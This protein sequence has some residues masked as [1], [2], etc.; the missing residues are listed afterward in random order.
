[1]VQF[2]LLQCWDVLVKVISPEILRLL[3]NP[4]W[5]HLG[6]LLFTGDKFDPSEV[7]YKLFRKRLRNQQTKVV[8]PPAV[9]DEKLDSEDEE[10][11]DLEELQQN[12]TDDSKEWWEDKT[13]LRACNSK[14]G[15]AVSY[16]NPYSVS[17]CRSF[18][19]AADEEIKLLIKSKKK[20]NYQNQAEQVS[21]LNGK[22]IIAR[23]RMTFLELLMRV[24][25]KELLELPNMRASI[26]INSPTPLAT[27]Q[28]RALTTSQRWSIYFDVI[29]TAR[30]LATEATKEVEKKLVAA[31][32]NLEAI[33]RVGDG[34]ILQKT[35]VVGMTTT[36]AAK[37]HDLLQM[38]KSKIGKIAMFYI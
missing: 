36:G 5:L 34:Q 18:I 4:E 16:I 15:L 20:P 26:G 33:Y 1:M 10:D 29:E 7:I 24:Q 2:H 6:D 35:K 9:N 28:L 21:T 25:K 22:I 11:Y 19:E 3:E 14:N 23:N 31:Q 30:E 17:F 32:K 12:R 37:N 27:S 13:E 8:S 38:M